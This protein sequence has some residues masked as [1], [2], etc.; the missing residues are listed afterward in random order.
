MEKG[1]LLPFWGRLLNEC[2]PKEKKLFRIIMIFSK[3]KT[4]ES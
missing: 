4:S 2:D 3:A 1:L